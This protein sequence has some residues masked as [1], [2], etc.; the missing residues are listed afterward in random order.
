MRVISDEVWAFARRLAVRAGGGSVAE[1]RQFDSQSDVS[2]VVAEL[3]NNCRLDVDQRVV[4]QLRDALVGGCYLI[5]VA[6]SAVIGGKPED[7]L[8]DQLRNR[9]G[10]RPWF[11]GR[12]PPV[13]SRDVIALVPPNDAPQPE[14]APDGFRVAAVMTAFNERDIV[15]PSIERLIEQGIEVYL[16]DNWSQDDTSALV[17]DL[18]GNGLI[19]IETFPPEGRTPDYEWTMLLDHVAK[20]AST[21]E[22]D[23]IV[24]H[25]VD[26]RRESPWP[27]IGY[28]DALYL[29]DR[30]GYSAVDHTILEFRPTDDD[31]VDGTEPSDHLS[32]FEFVPAAATAVHVQA[33]KNNGQTVDLSGSGGHDATFPGR[34]VFP[35]NFVLRH[36]PIRSQRHGDLK[37]FRDRKPRYKVD[38]MEKGWHYHYSRL[39]TG[40]RFLRNPA[41][42]LQWEGAPTIETYMLPILGQVGME[43]P[44]PDLTGRIRARFVRYLQ[45]SGLAPTYVKVRNRLRRHLR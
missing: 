39:R 20:V 9:L 6:D 36:Y 10:V 4:G 42:L 1:W 41:D 38:E 2:V 27:E 22:H 7:E 12:C 44:E 30:S 8:R 29:V 34:R 33:W 32:C 21:L 19:R 23:W 35:V 43:F 3:D 18:V 31:F 11:V 17:E 15:R 40:H 14:S 26:Q 13:G 24:H 37:V 5:V 45:M 28:R 16:I 25:D